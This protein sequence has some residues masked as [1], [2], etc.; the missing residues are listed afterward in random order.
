MTFLFDSDKTFRQTY[1]T[2][3]YPGWKSK[4][5]KP[6]YGKLLVSNYMNRVLHKLP[7]SYSGWLLIKNHD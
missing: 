3:L 7:V 6:S 4:R 2:K 1:P 5:K